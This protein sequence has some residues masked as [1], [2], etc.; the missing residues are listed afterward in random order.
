MQDRAKAISRQM[1]RWRKQKKPQF[2]EELEMRIDA[3]FKFCEEFSMLPDIEGLA[4]AV[5][6]HRTTVFRW[7]N[8]QG[9]SQLWQNQ[10]V[11]AYQLIDA[12]IA[13]AGNS[14]TISPVWAI[15][16]QKN[17][18]GYRDTGSLEERDSIRTHQTAYALPTE[19]IVKYSAL[20][21]MNASETI[22]EA[23]NAQQHTQPERIELSASNDPWLNVPELSEEGNEP[24]Y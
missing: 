15:W 13:E 18:S 5:G 23:Q 16:K 1:N 19:L 6:V 22:T 17:I 3:Y 12:A 9:C 2:Y 21:N 11:M 24:F 20:P 4:L 14:G 10:V 8:G 7:K